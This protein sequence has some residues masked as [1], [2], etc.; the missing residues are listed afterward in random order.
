VEIVVLGRSELAA[1]WVLAFLVPVLAHLVACGLGKRIGAPSAPHLPRIALLTA[2]SVG[3]LLWLTS[4]RFSSVEIGEDSMTLRYPPPLARLCTVPLS[5]VKE[6]K[7]FESA[8]PRRSYFVSIALA[9]GEIHRSVGLTPRHLEPLYAIFRTF[10]PGVP[11]H[12]A[13]R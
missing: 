10:R 2:A 12:V 11:P 1:L 7:M 3:A 13:M 6:V 5:G 8:F 9:S 4:T